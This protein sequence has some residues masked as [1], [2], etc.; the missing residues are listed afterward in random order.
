MESLLYTAEVPFEA[1]R[2][3]GR[4][5]H[6]HSFRL[7]AR[8]R[9]DG[10]AA[11]P[12]A[13]AGACAAAVAPLDYTLL[14]EHLD[15]PA[16][17]RVL[18]E[19]GRR[20][21]AAGVVPHRLALRSAPD[22]GVGREGGAWAWRAFRFEAA[23]RLPYV[24][25]GHPCGRMH[26]HGYL[27]VLE[28]AGGDPEALGEAWA[29]LGQA[30][31]RACLNDFLDNPTSELIAVWLWE[32]LRPRCPGLIRLHVHETEHSGCT[33]DGAQHTIWKAQRFEAA[34]CVADA[35]DTRARLHGH[36]YRLRVHVTAPLDRVLGWTLDYGDV[37]AA[38]APVREALD[39]QRLDTIAGLES[40]DVAS[41]AAWAARAARQRLPELLRVDCYERDGVGAIAWPE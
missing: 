10:G 4:G 5:W 31:D 32:Q 35:D 6:G 8:V 17:P 20:L 16:D 14:N 29:P 36:G 11:D 19:L 41:L 13:L 40:G 12:D 15:D 1:A 34:T 38:F 18:D 9:A 39:H 27:V 30:L 24:P 37:K 26:G 23:H 3:D 28:A 33:Y 22:R 25:E 7:R 2:R 21:E